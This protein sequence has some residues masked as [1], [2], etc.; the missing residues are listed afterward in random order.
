MFKD[1]IVKLPTEAIL[2][3]VIDETCV[4]LPVKVDPNAFYR[5]FQTEI[6]SVGLTP[7]KAIYLAAV[8]TPKPTLSIK[9]LLIKG[10]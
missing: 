6:E 9:S 7:E 4:K 3:T 5:D 2:Q 8:N 1:F 10:R